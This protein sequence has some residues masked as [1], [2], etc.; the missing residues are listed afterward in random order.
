MYS[1]YYCIRVLGQ[2]LLPDIAIG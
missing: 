2:G 1:N